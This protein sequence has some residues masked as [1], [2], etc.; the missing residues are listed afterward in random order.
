MDSL[1]TTASS[2]DPV[3]T[4][5][6]MLVMALDRAHVPPLYR[7]SSWSSFRYDSHELSKTKGGSNLLSKLGLLESWNGSEDDTICFLTGKPGTGKTHLAAATIRRYI[8][9]G[10]KGGLFIVT[11]EFLQAIKRGFS[12]G[13]ADGVVRQAKEATLLVLDDVGS[14]MATDWVRDTLYTLVNY[15]M[16]HLKPTLVTSNLMPSEIAETY[17]A[18][19]A[20]RL[21][22]GLVLDMSFLPDRRIYG[23]S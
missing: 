16:N 8:D 3:F 10:K 22:S 9:A 13:G 15:R 1:S 14:E 19:L 11:G 6:D 2:D 12:T 5:E 23:G 18:R 21:V 17:H 4:A 20:S 7:K